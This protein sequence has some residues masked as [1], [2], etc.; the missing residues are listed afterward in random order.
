MRAQEAYGGF[1]R[2]KTFNNSCL[3]YRAIFYYLLPFP[4]AQRFFFVYL[5]DPL[6]KNFRLLHFLSPL[7]F[8][9]LKSLY[10]EPLFIFKH[11]SFDSYTCR[12]ERSEIFIN[13]VYS[14]S[15]KCII[16]IAQVLYFISISM[17]Y[18]RVSNVLINLKQWTN[19]Q[20]YAY[21]LFKLK[22][23]EKY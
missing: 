5:S 4:L 9:R 22:L 12:Q 14:R 17:I 8:K 20:K 21:M 19:Q 16:I 13:K 2:W 7:T 1:I 3:L 23:I 10:L 11:F 15:L 6:N 18:L